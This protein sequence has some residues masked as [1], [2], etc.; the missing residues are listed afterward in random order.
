MPSARIISFE[1]LIVEC[2]KLNDLPAWEE[3]HGVERLGPGFVDAK[4]GQT[5]FRAIMKGEN[6]AA[7]NDA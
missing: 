4:T 6:D 2:V 1:R 3:K 7:T 5:V